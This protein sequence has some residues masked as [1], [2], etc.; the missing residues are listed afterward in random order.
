MI[1]IGELQI[2]NWVE[3]QGKFRQISLLM[4]SMDNWRLRR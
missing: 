3:H 4:R 1:P 2:G